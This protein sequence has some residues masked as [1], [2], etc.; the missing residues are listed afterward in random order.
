MTTLSD[1]QWEFIKH[2]AI[3]VAYADIRGFKLTGGEFKRTVYQQTEY[4]A[5]GK[6]KTMLS[7]HLYALAQDYNIFFDYDNDGDKD[8][9]GGLPDVVAICQELGDFWKSL[10]PDNYWGGDWGWDTPHFGRKY[11]P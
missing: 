6:S 5:T 8:Y 9:T 10:H 2:L 7:D 11:N 3:L 4:V 1:I